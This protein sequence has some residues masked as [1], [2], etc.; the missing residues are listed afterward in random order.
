M[1]KAFINGQMEENMR[2]DT[3]KIKKK[4]MASIPTQMEEAT[5]VTGPTACNTAM[6]HVC[7]QMEKK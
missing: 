1:A 5:K 7:T 4:V 2:V 3:S 6:E